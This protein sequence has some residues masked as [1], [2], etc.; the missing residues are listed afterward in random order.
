MV[1]K[2]KAIYLGSEEKVSKKNNK[3]TVVAF[4]D[5]ATQARGILSEGFTGSLPKPLTE[6]TITL[7]IQLGQYQKV[8]VLGFE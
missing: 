1:G 2:L 3:Y 8:T 7:D 5:G 6:V 4:M